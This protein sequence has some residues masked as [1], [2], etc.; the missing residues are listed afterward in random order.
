MILIFCLFFNNFVWNY[1]EKKHPI[2][3]IDNVKIKEQ[4]QT[5]INK[6]EE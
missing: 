6:K 5:V 3:N 1:T 4:N 2:K